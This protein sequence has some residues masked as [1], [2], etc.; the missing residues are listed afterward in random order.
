MHTTYCDGSNTAEEMVAG[1]V[2]RNLRVAGLS[3][4][5][6]TWF[7]TSYCMSPED[8]EAYIAELNRL[9]EKYAGSIQVLLG[10]EL[11]YWSDIDTA[12]YDYIIG[13]SHYVRR[14]SKYLDI[15]YYAELLLKEI[16]E[17]FAGDGVSMAQAYYEQ[18][19]DIV[20]K[21]GCDIIG[22]FDL[23]TKFNESTDPG[24]SGKPFRIIDTEDERYTAAWKRAVDRIFEDT[25]TAFREGRVNRLEQLGVIRAGNKPVFE[26]N[27]GAMAKG[28]RTVPY[29]AADQIEY[30]RSKGGVLIL[31]SDSH[32]TGTICHAFEEITP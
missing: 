7:D 20:R 6:F 32:S 19:G 13:S 24:G 25:E 12:P 2:S 5:S 9:K 3:G 18:V 16:K 15:D 8:T 14:D 31:S 21:T 30:I 4:H 1:A 10:T 27:T 22:H 26:I 29:P 23:I 28:Y 17:H 11:D